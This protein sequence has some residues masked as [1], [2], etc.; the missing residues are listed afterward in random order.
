MYF[1]VS[2]TSLSIGWIY[3]TGFPKLSLILQRLPTKWKASPCGALHNVMLARL[4][5]QDKIK[6]VRQKQ[7]S[8]EAHK[9]RPA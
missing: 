5:T 7:V 4:W 1:I 9:S 2:I 6:Q 3:K 8:L